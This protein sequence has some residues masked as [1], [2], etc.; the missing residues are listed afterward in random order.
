M[1]TK[2]N[3]GCFS[4]IVG[5]GV[6]WA[7]PGVILDECSRQMPIPV[8]TVGQESLSVEFSVRKSDPTSGAIP[9][10]PGATEVEIGLKDSR[11]EVRRRVRESAPWVV[12]PQNYWP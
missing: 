12:K 11:E 5:L 4:I 3:P 1:A 2:G 6:L 7:L 9:G 10:L 8:A